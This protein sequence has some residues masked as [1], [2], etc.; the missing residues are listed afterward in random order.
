MR[1]RP[2]YYVPSLRA[3][4]PSF[5]PFYVFPFPVPSSS[6]LSPIGE[7][8]GP[9]VFFAFVLKGWPPNTTSVFHSPHPPPPVRSF[10]PPR[11]CDLLSPASV[12]VFPWQTRTVDRDLF[13][14][15][16]WLI[17][18]FFLSLG[19]PFPSLFSPHANPPCSWASRPRRRD[20]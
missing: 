19:G 13:F 9:G 14:R 16:S 1:W 7:P 11:P 8:G 15:S 20:P 6:G 4:G 17:C 18:F 3:R 10:S 5:P 2:L 12:S